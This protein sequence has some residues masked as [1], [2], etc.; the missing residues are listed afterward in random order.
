MKQQTEMDTYSD[1]YGT[2]HDIVA[3]KDKTSFHE[4]VIFHLLTVF[5][6]DAGEQL[7]KYVDKVVKKPNRLPI[8]HHIKRVQQLNRYIGHLL[9]L[10]YRSKNVNGTL[11]KVKPFHHAKLAGLILE[12]VPESWRVD[13]DKMIDDIPRST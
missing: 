3:G 2:K 13:R 5:R 11:N 6:M 8:R 9:C 10:H 1:V 7:C 12:H 4:C